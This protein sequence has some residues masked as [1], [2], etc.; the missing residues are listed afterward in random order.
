[1]AGGNIKVVV[2]VRPFNSRG[3]AVGCDAS[4][5]DPVLMRGITNREGA[6][7]EMYRSDERHANGP[8]TAAGCRE[9]RQ[10]GRQRP[11]A[12]DFQL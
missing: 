3:T 5:N 2:R 1:M 7:C 10:R 11:R 6:E 12:K 4:F 9:V 8:H